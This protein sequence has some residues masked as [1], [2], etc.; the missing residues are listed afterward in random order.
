MLPRVLEPETL[1]HLAADDPAAQRSRRDLRRV[2]RA[3]GARA[4]LVRALGRVLPT[5]Q[6]ASI[7]IL[8]IG[9]GDG[10][11]LLDV[12][13]RGGIAWGPSVEL[14]LL[15]RQSLVSTATLAAYADVGWHAEPRNADV[16]DWAGDPHDPTRWDVVVANLFLHHFD[17][18]ALAALLAGCSRRADAL[19]ACEPRRSRFALGAS[20]LVAF[21]GANAVT[22]RDAVLSVRAGFVGRELSDAWPADAGPW[23]LDE[24]DDGLFTH[25]FCAARMG[26]RK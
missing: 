11:L 22:R 3:M 21:L 6:R 15:D 4:I 1:D 25:C 8:E 12:A 24:Y 10:M 18:A 23:R 20:H 14:T 9:C 7:R 17:G 16:L 13:R 2:N 19:V 26:A 5:R